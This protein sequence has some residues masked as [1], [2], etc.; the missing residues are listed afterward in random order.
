MKRSRLTLFRIG[1]QTDVDPPTL[2]ALVEDGD[3]QRYLRSVCGSELL[4]LD[5][6]DGHIDQ[7]TTLVNQGALTAQQVQ[8]VEDAFEARGDGW[9]ASA[10]RYLEQRPRQGGKGA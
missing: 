4:S 1:D 3:G 5:G 8:E 10:V 9:V 6:A 7:P 2:Y